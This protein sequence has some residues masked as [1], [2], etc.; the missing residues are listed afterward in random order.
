MGFT[1]FTSAV[2]QQTGVKKC[3]CLSANIQWKKDE[4]PVQKF[5]IRFLII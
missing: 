5:D 1:V 3:N 4:D 2:V